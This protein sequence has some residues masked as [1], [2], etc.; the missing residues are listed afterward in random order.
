MDSFVDFLFGS[1]KKILG[2]VIVGGAIVAGIWPEQTASFLAELLGR[3]WVAVQPL[4]ALAKLA[5]TL[6]IAYFG[7]RVMFSGGSDGG[8]G[9]GSKGGKKK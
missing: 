4:G 5:I 8:G 1:P 6:A 3:L 9:G 7:F 2:T